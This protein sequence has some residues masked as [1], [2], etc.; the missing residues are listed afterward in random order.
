MR[1]HHQG[2]P[3]IRLS[4]Q[5]LQWS[6]HRERRQPTSV[7]GTECRKIRATGYRCHN[8][9]MPSRD[10]VAN[11]SA[12]RNVERAAHPPALAAKTNIRIGLKPASKPKSG[13]VARRSALPSR[14]DIIS[15]ACQVRKVQ[16]RTCR[17]RRCTAGQIQRHNGSTLRV[18]PSVPPQGS[19][20]LRMRTPPLLENRFC[21]APRAKP[22]CPGE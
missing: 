12:T 21:C 13:R 20:H 3:T 7:S 9:T 22:R 16:G 18:E 6:Y 19:R 10:P 17:R 14:T 1:R 4:V 8:F 5:Q 2:R 11:A 15:G